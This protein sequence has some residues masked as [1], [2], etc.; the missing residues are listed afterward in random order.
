MVG[1][2]VNDVFFEKWILMCVCMYKIVF[3]VLSVKWWI[4]KSIKDIDNMKIF[5]LGYIL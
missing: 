1:K 5:N 3:V 4:W 2:C